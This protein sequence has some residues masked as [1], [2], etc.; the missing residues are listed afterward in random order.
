MSLLDF[1]RRF[2][3]SKSRGQVSS[4]T[5]ANPD[6]PADYTDLGLSSGTL[7]G[8]NNA[9]GFYTFDEAVSQFGDCLPS[10]AQWMELKANC[11]WTW[12]GSGY[13]VTG[14]NGN[15]IELPAE[16]Y[17]Y[18]DGNICYVGIRGN[19]WSSS[20]ADFDA[21]RLSFYSEGVYMDDNSRCDAISV[22]LVKNN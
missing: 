22:R 3:S 10:R 6:L 4:T 8:D 9:T 5:T 1:S 17:R 21:W 2:R 12:T 19:Y 13:K 18:R 16:G 7:W 14:P 15:S 20:P 11:K